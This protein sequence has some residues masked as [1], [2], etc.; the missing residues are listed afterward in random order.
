MA[1]KYTGSLSLEWFNKQKSILVQAEETGRK[2]GE[3]PAPKVDWINKDEALFYEIV[4]EEGRGLSPYWVDRSDLR[5][6]EARPLSFQKAYTAVEKPKAGSLI[7]KEYKLVQSSE[8][9][10]TIENMLIRGD[11]LLALNALKKL[12]ESRPDDE[13]VKCIFIDPPYN[14]G[15]AFEYYED[16]MAHSEWLTL[17]RD[18]LIVLRELLK[19]D[20]TIWISID[21][22]EGHYLKVLCDEIFSRDCFVATVIWR[23]TDNSNND[24]KQL[25]LDHNMILVYSKQPEW[26]SNR[27]AAL[28]EQQAHFKNP[29]DDP[30]GAWFDGNPISSPNYRKNLCYNVTSPQ[31][32][33]VHFPKNGWRWSKETM[34]EKIASG[35]IRFTPDGKAIRRRTYLADMKGIPPSTLWADLESTGHNRQAK[36]EQKKIFPEREKEELFDT[37]KPERLL[38]KVFE[39][40][41]NEG[42]LVLDCFGGSGTTFAAAQKMGRH[43]IGV[44]VGTQTDV[45]IIP[46]LKKVLTGKDKGGITDLVDW[47]GGGSFKYYTLGES[48]IEHATRDFNWKLGREFIETSLLSSYDFAPDPEFSLSQAEL[49]A[50]S[51]QPAVGFHRVGQKQ[52]AGVVSLGEPK[53]EK[54][55]SYDELMAWYG[56]LKKF[57]GTQSITIFTNRSVELAYDSKPEDLEVI[58]VPHAI[59]AELEK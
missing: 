55:I 19:A 7:D 15:S 11:N 39:V 17:T 40:A 5:V 31:G 48:I 52:M 44:E 29:D 25:S 43:W 53:K 51:R 2:N 14:T 42:D 9:D 30:R 1:K 23:S 33:E 8:D 32:F 49:V 12:F 41:T 13:K 50:A 3:V 38:K 24:A 37:P 27:I 20:G 59:F 10:P 57:K 16:S 26:R 18:R 47:Q 56:S 4:D 22:D 34:E 45:H 6:K 58:K 21:D 35:E 28:P 54:P 36:Y 46:R